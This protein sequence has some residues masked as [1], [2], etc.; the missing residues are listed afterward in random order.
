METSIVQS[1]ISMK[2]YLF[3]A[4]LLLILATT[5]KSQTLT[6]SGIVMDS[7]Y[8]I[9]MP[10]VLVKLQKGRDT[11][12]MQTYTN[13][14]GQF[15]FNN[16]EQGLYTLKINTNG[17]TEKRQ[18][19]R[20]MENKN[21]II[22][23]NPEA[24]LI[25]KVILKTEVA[26]TMK[27]DTT[28]FNADSFKTQGNATAEDLIKKLPGVTTENGEVKAQG[29]KVQRVLID[30]KPYFGDDPKAA[31]KN[32]AAEAVDK[33]QVYDGKS[34]KATFSG[35]DDGETIKTINIITKPNMRNGLYGKVNGGIGTNGYYQSGLNLNKT[36]SKSRISVIGQSNNVNQQNFSLQDVLGLM[37]SSG[38]N[39]RGNPSGKSGRPMTYPGNPV[40][41]FFVD[42]QNGVSTTN[43]AGVNYASVVNKKLSLSASYFVNNLS[44]SNLQNTN[45]TSFGGNQGDQVY[46]ENADAL[47]KSLTHRF[48]GRL[49]YT[50]D[51]AN[52]LVYVPTISFQNVSSNAAINAN[53]SANN[54]LLNSILSQTVKKNTGYSIKNSATYSHR[55]KKEGKTITLQGTVNLAPN[56]GTTNLNSLNTYYLASTN[57]DTLNQLTDIEAS[58]NTYKGE[59]SYTSL[60]T[61]KAQLELSG[62]YGYNKNNSERVNYGFSEINN[63]YNVLDTLLSSKFD[64]I[65]QTTE[66]GARIRHN[67]EKLSYSYGAAV[68]QNILNNDQVFPTSAKNTATFY[69][70]VPRLFMRYKPTKY[71]QFFT[72]YR[73]RPNVPSV[74]QL[75]DVV[76]NTNPLNLS[77]GNPY[78]KQENR[79]FMLGRY[80][81]M[82]PFSG[83]SF[84]VFG[85]IQAA[86]SY[87]GNETTIAF[88]PTT[89]KEGIVLQRGAQYTR[90]TNLSG[91]YTGTASVSMGRKIKK[92]KSNL[93]T[94][95]GF[96]GS[97]TPSLINN[98]K[99][100]NSNLALNASVNLTSNISDKIDFNVG[101]AATQ[102]WVSN[103]LQTSLNYNYIAP[104]ANG[105]AFWM[106]YKNWFAETE[107]NY[108]LY[109][110]LSQGYNPNILL[111]NPALGYRSTKNVWEIK[112]YAFD[113]LNQN[114]AIARNVGET[115]VEDI[116]SL[117][118]QRYAMI[119]VLYNIRKFAKKDG[120][121]FQAEDPLE[122]RK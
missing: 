31:L 113:V 18:F 1:K 9:P 108:T 30:G 23:L 42:N 48:N 87:I 82:D 111:I 33:V 67:S 5:L 94:T 118:I 91:Y 114:K 52:K 61:K 25:E 77:S 51:S 8:L 17:F 98:Q 3:L 65:T 28:Q 119:Q 24:K 76:N 46:T 54:A 92:L 85:L 107:I 56:S 110:G 2:K 122:R 121:V 60:L 34:E 68:Q 70:F 71:K 112:L 4:S 26:I 81:N 27:G 100:I 49:E 7:G 6:Y 109:R 115:Y 38:G 72:F 41:D 106:F 58:G 96:N 59:L 120:P 79:H 22:F 63:Q 53:T 73:I 10:G 16:L 11:G 21:D 64:N 89:T 39:M 117:V 116:S 66:I 44:T 86:N 47:S 104:S 15:Q 97:R 99:N 36:S 93:N 88:A 101:I 19:V 29:E 78:L 95:L 12:V 75:Q 69:A 105:K 40:N 74:S 90:P 45:R 84:F 13:P 37:G 83:K 62:E 102:T 20:L 35:F 43:A 55:F 14:D 50:M 103:N 57:I 80:S 32:I